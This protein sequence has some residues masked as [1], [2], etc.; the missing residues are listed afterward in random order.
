MHLAI[1]MTN[2]DDSAF[3]QRHPGDG[4]KFAALIR[5]ARPDWRVTVFAVKDGI[6]P[7][8]MSRFDGALITGS[9]ASTRSGAAWTLRLFDLIRQMHA[10]RQ[11]LMGVC[12]GHQAIALALGGAVGDNPEGWAH[13]LLRAEML[14]RP[15]WTRDLPDVLRLYGS[16]CEQ[17]TRAPEGAT[18]L[19][20]SEGCPIA[21]F[22]LGQHV[23]TTQHHPEMERDFVADLT[24]EMAE[25]LGPERGAQALASLAEPADTAAF[26]ESIARFFEQ[27]ARRQG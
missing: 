20:R 3:A 17:V 9:P 12:F 11:P 19:A 6:F 10:A 25:T 13:G 2:T 14:A 16:H 18:V 23:Y 27:G 22:S 24:G 7:E 8:D 26:A 4:E 1:L 5:L 21:G 15:D